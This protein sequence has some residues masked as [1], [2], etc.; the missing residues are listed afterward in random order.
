MIDF[1]NYK[2][3]KDEICMIRK[4]KTDSLGRPPGERCLPT[5]T[6]SKETGFF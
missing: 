3:F 4:F 2:N 1:R 5:E 6:S